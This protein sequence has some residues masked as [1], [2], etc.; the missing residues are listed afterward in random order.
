MIF[1]VSSQKHFKFIWL[2]LYCCSRILW[3]FKLNSSFGEYECTLVEVL[4]YYL[5]VVRFFK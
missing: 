1:L 5:C 3:G 2:F 4:E